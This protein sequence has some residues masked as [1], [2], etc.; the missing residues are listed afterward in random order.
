MEEK[1]RPMVPAHDRLW[2]LSPKEEF[3]AKDG[4]VWIL[5]FPHICVSSRNASP[6]LPIPCVQVH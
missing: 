2:D 1:V 6:V 5:L 3:G 4:I